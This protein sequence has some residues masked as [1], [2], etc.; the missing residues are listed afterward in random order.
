M[1]STHNE[2]LERIIDRLKNRSTINWDKILKE[3][4]IGSHTKLLTEIDV[5]AIKGNRV[6]IFEYKCGKNHRDKAMHQLDIQKQ[7][8]EKL[9][10]KV[11]KFY[12]HEN[13]IYE[14]IK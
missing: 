10:Y 4:P 9:H 11:A 5:I 12:V 13:D 3:Y 7:Y 2:G 1:K 6:A 14:W 8:L